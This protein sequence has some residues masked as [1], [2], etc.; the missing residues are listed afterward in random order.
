MRLIKSGRR[1]ICK[2]W[3]KWSDSV[4]MRHYKTVPTQ[5]ISSL[6]VRERSRPR[7]RHNRFL[8]L[9]KEV[10]RANDRSGQGGICERLVGCSSRA[11][12]L[13]LFERNAKCGVEFFFFLVGARH[14]GASEIFADSMS[15]YSSRNP[16]MLDWRLPLSRDARRSETRPRAS[17]RQSRYRRQRSLGGA[18]WQIIGSLGAVSIEKD[19]QCRYQ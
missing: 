19:E 15:S 18:G 3:D 16:G 13:K 14:S 6:A 10:A 2:D 17:V 11:A 7:K 1:D 8:R 9:W 4:W 12:K 5:T